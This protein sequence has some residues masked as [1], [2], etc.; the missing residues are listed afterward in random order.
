VY[1]CAYTGSFGE[2][3]CNPRTISSFH[4]NHMITLEG[5]VTKC[6]LVRPKVV[7]SVHY[8]EK[9]NSFKFR[10]YQ[11]QTMAA[12]G[13]K[14]SNVYPQEDPETGDPVIF[15]LSSPLAALSILF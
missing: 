5:I 10:T 6:G 2:F 7:R 4:L 1:Y 14:T 13:V 15:I 11:D 9:Q 12:S 8:N 3:S